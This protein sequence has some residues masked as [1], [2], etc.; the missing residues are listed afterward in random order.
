MQ[1]LKVKIKVWY[2]QNNLALFLKVFPITITVFETLITS[3]IVNIKFVLIFYTSDYITSCTIF[4][5]I[6]NVL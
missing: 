2:D 4:V 1:H 3:K 5:Y 6:V